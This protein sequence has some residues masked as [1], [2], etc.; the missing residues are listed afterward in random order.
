[1]TRTGARRYIRPICASAE[2]A[3]DAAKDLVYR[4]G[5]KRR[6][7]NFEKL[8]A[9]PEV[10]A[11]L[12]ADIPATAT[13]WDDAFHR[14]YCHSCGLEDC[15]HCPHEAERNNLAWWLMQT[16][17]ATPSDNCHPYSAS[18]RGSNVMGSLLEDN[19]Q[20][21][22][23]TFNGVGGIVQ[24]IFTRP[25][26]FILFLVVIWTLVN[27][28]RPYLAAVAVIKGSFRKLFSGVKQ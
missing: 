7:T 23:L 20:N 5:Q 22:F 1:M 15:D 10:L 3:S 21:A 18:E 12:L 24:S 14:Q 25:I 19:W 17:E 2:I 11:A 9:S 28:T 16:A 6:M 26:T 8:T 13:P 4:K 27:K